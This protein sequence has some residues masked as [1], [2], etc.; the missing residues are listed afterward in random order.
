MNEWTL[1]RNLAFRIGTTADARL[2]R[3]LDGWAENHA[4]WLGLGAG[5]DWTA[6][7]T[8]L[9]HD[10]SGD[11]PSHVLCIAEALARALSLAD[12]DARLLQLFVAID[13][14]PRVGGLAAIAGEHGRDLPALLGSMAG[15]TDGDAT[16]A[17]R[18]SVILRHGLATLRANG[19]GFVAA[20]LGWPL[21]RLLDRAT[22][23]D[24]SVRAAMIGP[25]QSARLSLDDF[26][27]VADLDFLV[28]L[29]GGAASTG[30]TGINILIHGPPGTGKTEI[31]RTLASAAGLSLHAVGEADDDGEEPS[32]W[33]RVTALHLAQRLTTASRDTVLLFDEMEDLIGDA[34]P[35]HGDWVASRQGSKVFV[36]RLLENNAV[37]VIWTTNAIGN[38]DA[39]ILRRMSY[40]LHMDH[41]GPAAAE[42][43]HARIADEEGIERH[44]RVTALLACAPETA[45]VLRVAARAAR[46]VGQ[47]DGAIRAAAS[48]VRALCGSAM[49][50]SSETIL[51]LDLFETDRPLAAIIEQL[52]RCA[53]NVSILLTGPPGTGKTALGHHLARAMDRR[54][55]V[56][57]ASDLLSCWVGGTEKAVA[58]AFADARD[59]EH[60]LLF[61]EV[62]S[63]LFDR[64]TATRS[65]EA[66][67]V[68]E[69][70][71]WLESHPLP[72]IAA[73]NHAHKLDPAALRRFVFKI[74]LAP[75]GQDRAGR[76]FQ[77][78]FA[79]PAPGSLALVTNLTPGDFAAVHRQLPYAPHGGAEDLVNRLAQEAAWR[80]DSSRIG[81]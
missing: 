20:E 30:T 44:T 66:G 35:S 75:L 58:Q 16:R 57:R 24:A 76:A 18:R 52:G 4:E 55:V 17:V 12:F 27:H 70:L 1:V 5:R 47:P 21:E 64:T 48:L 31:A 63:L 8:A 10:R 23:D 39:A 46:V 38:V 62:D 51:D 22:P 77:R 67:Q 36:N 29:V 42:R 33:D 19:R 61:D 7:R 14:L 73:T 2:G 25:R 9:E 11:E 40:I 26:A 78:F 68:N 15:V 80:P 56:K 6:A 60:V 41:P 69:M 13:R 53:N 3:A 43:M 37:P 49:P 81:F 50:V 65:W 45:T 34:R 79:V 32:R 28:R 71:T 59:R 54:L 74:D 72:V